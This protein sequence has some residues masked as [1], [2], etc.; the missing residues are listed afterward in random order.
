MNQI[1]LYMITQVN[2][3]YG[4]ISFYIFFLNYINFLI[5][6]ARSQQLFNEMFFELKFEINLIE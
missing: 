2:D 1:K 3:F 4:N 6:N 5:T